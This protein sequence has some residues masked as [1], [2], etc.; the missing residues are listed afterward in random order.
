MYTFK[1]RVRNVLIDVAFLFMCSGMLTSCTSKSSDDA[2]RLLN[3][4]RAAVSDDGMNI[5]FPQGSPGL[6]L[7]KS[8]LIERGSVTIPVIAPARVVASVAVVDSGTGKIVLFESP[9]VTSLYSQYQQSRVNAERTSKNLTRVKEMFENQGATAKDVTDAETDAAN[10]R[11]T[12]AEY[13]GKM[14][15][16]GFNPAEFDRVPPGTVW[17]ISDVTE[18][19]L[20]DVDKGEEVDVTFDAFPI[21][22]FV[23]RAEAVG[24]VV[25][26]TTRTVKVRVSMRNPGGKLLPGMFARVDFG[27]PING[28]IVLPASAVVTVEG[29]DYVFVETA[30]GQFTRRGVIV[31]NSSSTQ[32]VIQ[33]G[34]EAGEHV[35]ISGVMLL[36]GLSFGY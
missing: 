24:E 19:Q 15:A 10:A 3:S 17:L 28:V 4:R 20:R 31:L 1:K 2:P 27:D 34:L 12:I 25:D 29:K 22:K 32:A 23:G 21:R 35:V 7:I 9:D 6:Q 18:N 14:R 30:P 8:S 11:A 16:A 26:P 33:N 13:E 5:T 36:K